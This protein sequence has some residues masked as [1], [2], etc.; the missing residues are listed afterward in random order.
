MVAAIRMTKNLSAPESAGKYHR[1]ICMTGKNKGICYYLNGKRVVLGRLSSNDV[2][3]LD[4][5]AS[6]EHVELTRVNNEYTL[7]DLKSQNG[8]MVNDLKVTQHKLK[9]GDKI[10]IGSTVFKYSFLEVKE[11]KALV[12]FEDEDEEDE[13]EEEEVKKT[14]PKKKKVDSKEAKRK[15]LIYGLAAIML[16]FFFMD[17]DTEQVKKAKSNKTGST[18]IESS[19]K[20]TG[21]QYKEDLEVKEKVEAYIHRG[22]REA[23]EGNYFRAMQEFNL[24]LTLDPNDGEAAYHLNIAKQR[25]DEKIKDMFDQATKNK[26]SLKYSRALGTYCAIYKLLIEYKTDERFIEAKKNVED[27]AEKLGMKKSDNYCF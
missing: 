11:E 17:G 12:E 6:R 20:N 2:Q 9:S 18:V 25:L 10:I 14:K 23:R 26:D 24:A 16:I 7:T 3:V 22:R 13:E 4:T 21:I 8:V 5:Q 15:K 19:N 27:M 1:I